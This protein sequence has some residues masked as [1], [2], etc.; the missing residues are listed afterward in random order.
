MSQGFTAVEKLPESCPMVI[1]MLTVNLC[2]LKVKTSTSISSIISMT[3]SSLA[4]FEIK[5][6]CPLHSRTAT[7]LCGLG[8][9]SES[10]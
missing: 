2:S 10:C 5:A 1:L 6:L 8:L 3:F 4:L 7:G 9:I